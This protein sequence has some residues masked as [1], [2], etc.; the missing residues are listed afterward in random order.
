MYLLRSM[1]RFFL[2]RRAVCAHASMRSQH[3]ELARPAKQ[4]WAPLPPSL[5]PGPAWGSLAPLGETEKARKNGGKT[6]KKWARYGQKRVKESGSSGV[7]PG[8]AT[9]GLSEGYEMTPLA[10][11]ELMS[12]KNC[13]R[14]QGPSQT[15]GLRSVCDRSEEFGWW[16]PSSV[17]SEHPVPPLPCST[18]ALCPPSTAGPRVPRRPQPSGG[19]SLTPSSAAFRPPAALRKRRCGWCQRRP[20][21]SLSILIEPG[22]SCS[23]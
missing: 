8:A 15:K 19:S 17:S 3:P 9:G 5:G 7:G 4:L 10:C 1:S 11:V 23:G 18:A 21:P 22:W 6:G 20:A 12:L 16:A 14:L 13:S 2:A